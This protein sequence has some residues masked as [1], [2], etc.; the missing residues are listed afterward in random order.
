MVDVKLTAFCILVDVVDILLLLLDVLINNPLAPP[1]YDL[2]ADDLIFTLLFVDFC[3]IDCIVAFVIVVVVAPLLFCC[4]CCN[5]SFVNNFCLIIIGISESE[6]SSS[7]LEPY[8]GNTPS[9]YLNFLF[10]SINRSFSSNTSLY[11]LLNSTK[12]LL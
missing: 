3:W 9:I 7:D 12:F 10:S 8:P 1:I 2:L 4:C 5:I 6:S 11:C